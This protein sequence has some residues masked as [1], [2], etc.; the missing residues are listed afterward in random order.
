M[1]S[2]LC[3]ISFVLL[4]VF[5]ILI[6]LT[7]SP[8]HRSLKLSLPALWI[9]DMRYSIILRFPVL[10]SAVIFIPGLMLTRLPST[11]MSLLASVN[12]AG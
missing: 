1:W 5:L 10:I 8:F 7:S 2:R 9:E 3:S 6:D 4:Q 12:V 11:S